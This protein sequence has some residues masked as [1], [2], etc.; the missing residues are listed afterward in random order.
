MVMWKPEEYLYF[1]IASDGEVKTNVSPLITCRYDNNI[2]LA[3]EFRLG[4]DGHGPNELAANVLWTMEV[5]ED[6]CKKNAS[7]FR[8]EVLHMLPRG[9]GKLYKLDINEW[10]ESKGL[11]RSPYYTTK[12]HA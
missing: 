7:L 2:H 10:I 9:G 4:Y 8:D 3:P 1:E 11:N 5:A 6:E 12:S